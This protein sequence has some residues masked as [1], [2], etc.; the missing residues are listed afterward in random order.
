MLDDVE[1]ELDVA[2]PDDA[3]DPDMDRE[4]DAV[5]VAEGPDEEESAAEPDVDFGLDPEELA[6][7]PPDSLAD[8]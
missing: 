2:D 4:F 3:S 8:I 7:T 5:D 6:T 1:C